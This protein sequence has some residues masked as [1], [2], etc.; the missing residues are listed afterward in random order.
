MRLFG[1]S[2]LKKKTD[3]L[4][5]IWGA[6]VDGTSVEIEKE[7]FKLLQDIIA[8]K[9]SNDAKMMLADCYTFG[10]GCS[11][12]LSAAKKLYLDISQDLNYSIAFKFLGNIA[13]NEKEETAFKYYENYL[14][15]NPNDNE[16]WTSLADCCYKGL[17]ANKDIERAMVIY[18][19][20]SNTDYG[21]TTNFQTRYGI[22]LDEQRYAD[23]I[24]WLLKATNKNDSGATYITAKVL[25]NANYLPFDTYTPEYRIET[26]LKLYERAY[27]L[28]TAENDSELAKLAKDSY[29]LFKAELEANAFAFYFKSE[30]GTEEAYRCR[31]KG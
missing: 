31:L 29:T 25:K 19:R 30:D 4:N 24:S 3:R 10:I 11:K 23:S 13:Y 18:K 7:A 22:K 28:A 8:E 6:A 15:F 2:R 16:V 20:V 12:N 1:K 17:G 9:P 21:N 26:S 27:N 5:A 14:K